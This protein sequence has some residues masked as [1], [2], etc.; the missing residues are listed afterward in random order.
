[1]QKENQALNL[2]PIRKTAQWCG[3]HQ[4]QLG[5]LVLNH[6]IQPDAQGILT[7]NPKRNILNITKHCF[8]T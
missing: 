3:F 1:M 5:K 6:E 2:F 8:M 4:N 7:G